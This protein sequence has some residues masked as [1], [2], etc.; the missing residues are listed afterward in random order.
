[1]SASG[2]WLRLVARRLCGDRSLEELR[3]EA[4]RVT[5]QRTQ[6][7]VDRAEDV[8]AAREL[9]SLIESPT[10]DDLRRVLEQDRVALLEGQAS[11]DPSLLPADTPDITISPVQRFDDLL[12]EDVTVD[13]I[14]SG[15]VCNASADPVLDA[16]WRTLYARSMVLVVDWR[17]DDS[18]VFFA[19]TLMEDR[20]HLTT[21][22]ND[23]ER[24]VREQFEA[25]QAVHSEDDGKFWGDWQNHVIAVAVR[26]CERHG[27][28][29]F[30]C[31]GG[32]ATE[33]LLTHTAHFN[34]IMAI[35]QEL[36]L[37]QRI[38]P[39]EEDEQCSVCAERGRD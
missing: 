5:L 24:R 19:F 10:P 26:E 23:L 27:V 22:M 2:G 11:S 21:V 18:D 16:L 8:R 38:T 13:Q 20:L 15:Q 17:A 1:M 12:N 6:R 29:V 36:G 28:R 35:I 3:A 25:A 14:R 9:L 34:R 4:Q 39:F 30:D 37:Q 33:L 32:D 31:S 7:I